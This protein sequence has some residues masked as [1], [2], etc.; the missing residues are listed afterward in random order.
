MHRYEELDVWQLAYQ[1]VR[2]LYE[3]TRHFPR[4]ERFGL[5]SQ[6]RSA[7]VSVPANIA[8]GSRRLTPGEFRQFLGI[9]AGSNAE[10]Q[11]L[12][13][14]SA[15]LGLLAA[16]T[17]AARRATTLSIDRMLCGLIRTLEARRKSRLPPPTRR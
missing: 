9:A 11:V 12:I 13:R 16:R 1:L 2:D 4:D 17:A 14:L 8:E 10:L 6:I 15:E 3:D 5:I 7:A